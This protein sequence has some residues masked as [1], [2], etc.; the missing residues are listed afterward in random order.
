MNKS[1]AAENPAT[2]PVNNCYSGGKPEKQKRRREAPYLCFNAGPPPAQNLGIW[3][4]RPT[5]LIPSRYGP[6]MKQ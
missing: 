4:G 2:L 6:L 1:T 3:G 5:S